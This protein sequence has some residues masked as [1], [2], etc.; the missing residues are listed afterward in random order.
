MCG[1]RSAARVSGSFCEPSGIVNTVTHF[2]RVPRLAVVLY[3]TVSCPLPSA[4]QEP[5]SA[6]SLLAHFCLHFSRKSQRHDSSAHLALLA[7]LYLPPTI[8][9]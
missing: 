2:R 8:S 4:K 6:N 9:P 7:A 3:I 5:L 1:R